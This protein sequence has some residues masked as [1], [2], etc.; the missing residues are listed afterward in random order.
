MDV[1]RAVEHIIAV[2]ATHALNMHLLERHRLAVLLCRPLELVEAALG[3][4]H[5]PLT[6]VLRLHHGERTD[7]IILDLLDLEQDARLVVGAQ[8]L[9]LVIGVPSHHLLYLA[10]QALGLLVLLALTLHTDVIV[11]VIREHGHLCILVEAAA[12]CLTH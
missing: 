7:K 10:V 2:E 1:V 5:V 4:L 8:G 11:E 3:A 9:E 6:L 12:A